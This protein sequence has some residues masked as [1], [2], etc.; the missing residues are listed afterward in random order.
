[1]N[2]TLFAVSLFFVACHSSAQVAPVNPAVAAPQGQARIELRKVAGDLLELAVF[3]DSDEL[4][5]VD[6]DAVALETK[7]GVQKRLPGGAGTLYTIEPGRFHYLNAR[8]DFGGVAAGET[9]SVRFDKVV[10]QRGQPVAIAP[11]QLTRR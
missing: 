1:M 2:K 11:M 7:N 3:N 8:F 9:V 10:M 4:L 6:R 5:T